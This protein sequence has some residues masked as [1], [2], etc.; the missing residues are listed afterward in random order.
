MKKLIV[1]KAVGLFALALT[2][3][4]C[5]KKSSNL[6]S[7]KTGWNY[8]DPQLGG[9]EVPSFAGQ[10]VGP[11]LRFVEGGTF[12][13]GQT[14]EDLTMENNNTPKRVSVSSFFM[15]E[16]EVANVHYREYLYWLSRTYGS[17]YPE[18]YAAALPD[19]QSWRSALQYN[20][21]QVEYYLRMASYN[22]YPVV[23]VSWEQ[24]TEYCKWRT[25]RVNEMILIQTGKLKKN[26]NQ[27]SDDN[28]NTKTYVA[29]QYEGMAGVKKKDL[30]PTGAKTR[31]VRYED[32]ILLP[33]YR[34]PTEAEWEF[35]AL[36]LI[37]RNPEPDSKRR[38]GEE[39]VTD[40]QIYPWGDNLSAREGQRTEYQGEFL[41]NFKRGGGDNMGVAGGLNDNA[42][43]PGPIYSYKP[44]SYGLFNMAG[45][46][47]E[48]VMDV[49]RP[50]TPMDA[51]DFRPFRGNVFQTYKT[52]EDFTMEEKDSLG[53]M[54]KRNV[55][56]AELASKNIDYR[57]ADLRGYID[58]DSSIRAIYD[59]GN[60]TL[61]SN[62]AHVYKGGSW[63]DRQYFLSPGARRFMQANH[64]SS[65][66][67]FRCAMDR[68]GSPTL[69]TP[70]GNY[71]GQFGKGIRK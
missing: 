60:T 6:V 54:P 37:G 64:A 15:D 24:A 65:K 32:G 33:D 29:G 44:N 36:G 26:P 38:R 70:S 50:N 63:S 46:V 69:H 22:Y 39:V 56:D 62:D 8:N 42:D 71:F 49:Y 61:I 7:S 51:Q 55:T 48:W 11:G 1:I 4:S 28:F 9:F 5:G 53:R 34:L 18:V 47:S 17:D 21:P 41:G 68:L 40:R 16:A 25:D 58:G 13:M 43:I 23:G 52:M 14:D 2:F 67:G 57:T 35:A 10:Y 12:T 31:N 20:E 59:Y 3:A 45:N 30:D 27:V 66:I 19:T